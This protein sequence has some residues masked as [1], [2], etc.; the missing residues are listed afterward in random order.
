MTLAAA[1]PSAPRPA[2]SHAPADWS[3]GSFTEHA[4]WVVDPATLAW[5]PAVPAVRWAVER[6]IPDLIRAR[7]LPPGF[8]VGRVLWHLGSAI[9]GWWLIERPKGGSVS[10]AGVSRRLRRAAERL[11][12]TYIKLGQIIS[13]GEGIFP[14]EL[15]TEFKKCRDQVPPEPFDVVRRVVEDDLGRSL[16]LVFASFEREPVAAA[17]I[18]QVHRAVLV[19]G[20]PVVVKVQRPS[21]RRLVHQD[22]KILAWMAPY[23]VGRI[24]IAALANPPALVELFGETIAEELDF[25]LEAQNMLDVAHAFAE[26]D[27]RGYVVPRPH[28]TLVTPR[29]LVMERFDG[30]AFDDVPSI[31][32]AGI[33]GEDV[34]RTGMIGFMEGAMLH[35]IFHGDLHGGNLLILPDGRIGLLDYGI[36]GRLDEKKRLAFLR[37]LVGA[38]MNDVRG[39]LEAFR[40]LGGL[41]PDT[42]LDRM[43][44]EL[45]LDKPPPDMTQMSAEEITH[46]LQQFVKA[47]LAYG[48]RF[49]KELMLYV[50]NLVFLDGAI[51]SLAPQLDLFAEIVTISTYFAER[52]GERIAAD[53]GLA[54]EEFEF[55][56]TGIQASFGVDPGETETLTYEDLLERRAIIRDRMEA[57]R[58]ER[59][60]RRRLRH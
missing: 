51:A 27:Q 14:E 21:V 60:S 57:H 8:R 37:L 26:L 17:S 7:P 22:V 28:P 11:G 56:F 47:L 42:D 19:T 10:R 38:S 32:A 5:R 20:E 12:P 48:A 36:T 43:I 45:D 2:P 49:P 9:A 24:P 1:E 15:V 41:P 55:D 59:R 6:G 23:L 39:Q 34:V 16:D 13:S 52:H 46:E 50:K 35:G 58:D 54:E 44:V 4:P 30:F 40:D 29:V 3:L 31:E 33:S 25:R 53:V 18:A